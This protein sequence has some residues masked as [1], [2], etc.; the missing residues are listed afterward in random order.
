MEVRLLTNADGINQRRGVVNR[1]TTVIRR[2]RKR[3]NLPLRE[4]IR[5]MEHSFPRG[6]ALPPIRI[7]S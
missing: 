1:I 2:K 7:Y 6:A 3:Y 5:L 4:E